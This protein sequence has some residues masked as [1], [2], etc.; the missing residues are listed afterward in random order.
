MTTVSQEDQS[1]RRNFRNPKT[2][3]NFFGILQDRKEIRLIFLKNTK[4]FTTIWTILI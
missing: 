2:N 4:H 1:S 3:E